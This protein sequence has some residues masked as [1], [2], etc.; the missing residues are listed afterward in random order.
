[1]AYADR[2]FPGT[3]VQHTKLRYIWLVCWS[4][5]E[6]QHRHTGGAFPKKEL[7]AIEDRTGHKLLRRYGPGDGHGIIGGRVLRVGGSPVVKPSVV[8][9]NAMRSWGLIRPL[10]NSGEPPGR[11]EI[12]WRWDE[13]TAHR[14]QPEVDA[15][16]PSP[17]F[18]DPPPCP[19]GWRQDGKPLEFDLDRGQDEDRKI[20]A[21]WEQQRDKLGGQTLL[22]RLA[23]RG[24]GAPE[25][26]TSREVLTLCTPAEKISLRRARQAGAL[27]CIARGVHTALVQQMKDG[28]EL[29]G[30]TRRWLDV[31]VKDY[32]ADA[33]ALDLS[34]LLADA[35]DAIRLSKLIEATQTWLADG[36]GDL[37]RI[38]PI[39]REREMAQKPGRAL[40]DPTAGDRRATWRPRPPQPLTYRFD[41]VSS[42]LEELAGR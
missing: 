3:S 9:W 16:P 10:Q 15:E 30:E 41:R 17:I 29:A 25:R 24:A 19:P 13:L 36:A 2:F 20:R 35:P 40:L 6:L 42:F 34:G 39:F 23:E 38:A 5:M 7:A 14:S 26:L 27:A 1:M 31:A 18:L 32:G 33:T 37:A 4:Y 11:S 22:S 21:A 12:H 28:N 8:Y